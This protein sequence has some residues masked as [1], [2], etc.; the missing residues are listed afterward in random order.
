VTAAGAAWPPSTSPSEGG[1]LTVLFTDLVGSTQLMSRLGET[2]FDEV[3]SP[4]HLAA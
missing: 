2:A 4:L 1:T 3:A